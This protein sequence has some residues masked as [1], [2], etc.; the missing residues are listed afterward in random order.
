MKNGFG[1]R[2]EV[3]IETMVNEFLASTAAAAGTDV[4]QPLPI[5]FP[6]LLL[7]ILLLPHIRTHQAA[8]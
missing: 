4:V 1:Y 3:E 6:L 5:P 8:D 7:L 2:A